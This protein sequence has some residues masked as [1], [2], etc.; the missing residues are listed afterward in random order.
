M[1]TGQPDHLY[2]QHHWCCIKSEL[3]KARYVAIEQCAHDDHV[4][5]WCLLVVNIGFSSSLLNIPFATSR[6]TTYNCAAATRYGH[7]ININVRSL[8]SFIFCT[9]VAAVCRL[10]VCVDGVMWRRDVL[11]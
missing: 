8:Y 7:A 4:I 9:V 3:P 5:Q 2:I 10:M 11:Q 6:L 1:L